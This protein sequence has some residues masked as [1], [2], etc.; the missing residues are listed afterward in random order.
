MAEKDEN[1]QEQDKIRD[2]YKDQIKDIYENQMADEQFKDFVYA[3]IEVEALEDYL[4]GAV[5]SQENIDVLKEWLDFTKSYLNLNLNSNGKTI[6]NPID[7][8]QLVFEP[9]FELTEEEAGY[10]EDQAVDKVK[11]KLGK[12]YEIADWKLESKMIVSAQKR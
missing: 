7:K 6:E 4:D 2:S 5:E 1:E 11:E 12:E 10:I 3:W 8:N 9:D